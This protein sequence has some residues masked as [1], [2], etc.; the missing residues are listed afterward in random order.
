MHLEGCGRKHSWAN[1][2]LLIKHLEWFTEVAVM[3][4]NLPSRNSKPGRLQYER[5]L[6]TIPWVRFVRSGSTI[7]VTPRHACTGTEGRRRYS[8]HPFAISALEGG[9]RATSSGRITPGR[10]GTHCMD[11][12]VDIGAGLGGTGSLAPSGDSIPGPSTP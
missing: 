1:F 8:S 7:K 4:T 6:L 9:G 5:M 2:K 12:W 3:T 10:H 11:G